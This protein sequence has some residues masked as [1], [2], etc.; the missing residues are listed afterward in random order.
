[1]MI[2]QGGQHGQVTAQGGQLY[3]YGRLRLS[4]S[5]YMYVFS[6]FAQGGHSWV[7]GHLRRRPK[8]F[9][10]RSLTSVQGKI[11]KLWITFEA[12]NLQRF[13]T[14]SNMRSNGYLTPIRTL[15]SNSRLISIRPG[16][17][18]RA[19][20]IPANQS[21]T[22]LVVSQVFL[23]ERTTNEIQSALWQCICERRVRSCGTYVDQACR[24][25]GATPSQLLSYCNACC[26]FAGEC[27]VPP[28][29]T[30]PSPVAP[31]RGGAEPRRF[32]LHEILLRE[33]SIQQVNSHDF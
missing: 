4:S 14:C 24:S 3:N 11:K 23:A 18:Q 28:M 10:W 12:S 31:F 29:I 32:N 9:C 6:I 2:A 17:L 13:E 21:L 19:L 20:P 33:S 7:I 1:M 26:L 8:L 30:G 16:C 22:T 5:I 15:D 27:K 25:K